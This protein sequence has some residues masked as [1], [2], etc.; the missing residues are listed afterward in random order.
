MGHTHQYGVGYKAYERSA[1]T[2]KKA[3]MIYDA[4]CPNGIPGCA[5]PYFDYQHIP[6]RYFEPLEPL[7]MNIFNG[8]V[9][10]ASWI[11]DGPQGVGFGV[12]SDDEMMVMVIMYTEDSTGVEVNN[13]TSIFEVHRRNWRVYK[14]RQIRCTI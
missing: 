1:L 11:N 6:M 9:H 4:S 10:E 7:T 3:D 8:L 14:L 5:S 13:P 2:K 12:T